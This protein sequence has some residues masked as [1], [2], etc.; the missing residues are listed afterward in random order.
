M[1][2]VRAAVAES[3]SRR[4]N[5]LSHNKIYEKQF[6]D[7]RPVPKSEYNPFSAL[8]KTGQHS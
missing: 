8:A 5:A 2:V 6:R 4:P 7:F 3:L 1:V